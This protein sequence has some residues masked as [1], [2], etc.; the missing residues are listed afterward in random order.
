[1]TTFLAPSTTSANGRGSWSAA[2]SGYGAHSGRQVVSQTGS[3]S[4]APD[5]RSDGPP[6]SVV[7]DPKCGAALVARI[8]RLHA[9]A[10]PQN[11]SA[12]CGA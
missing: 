11:A 1:M 8:V 3:R 6:V 2:R 9:V 7:T 4:Q 12:S 5:S 10:D